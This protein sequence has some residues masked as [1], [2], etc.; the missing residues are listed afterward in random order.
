[1]DIDVILHALKDISI[2]ILDLQERII[3]IEKKL[4][5]GETFVDICACEG[6][7]CKSVKE[8]N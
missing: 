3:A 6:C 4:E 7:C 1:M 5:K 8:G 2:D